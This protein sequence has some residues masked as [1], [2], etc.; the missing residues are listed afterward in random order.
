MRWCFGLNHPIATIQLTSPLLENLS[1]PDIGACKKSF[2]W[3][4]KT[5]DAAKGAWGFYYC[6]AYEE[7]F[8]KDFWK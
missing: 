8:G 7:C 6:H 3:T 1:E 5:K 4:I 2:E